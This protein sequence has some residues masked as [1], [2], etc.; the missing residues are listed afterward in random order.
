MASLFSGSVSGFYTDA[1]GGVEGGNSLSKITNPPYEK[2]RVATI[3]EP[4]N[5]YY[6]R[7]RQ[8]IFYTLLAMNYQNIS[9]QY[10]GVVY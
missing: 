9:T 2:V 3:Q 7:A 5:S 10:I 4:F 8:R 6:G 1:F